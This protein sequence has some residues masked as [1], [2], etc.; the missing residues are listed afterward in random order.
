MSDFISNILKRHIESAKN[1]RPRIPGRFESDQNGLNFSSYE[2]PDEHN[3]IDQKLSE[4]DNVNH[5]PLEGSADNE[6]I[7]RQLHSQENGP[8]HSSFRGVK[9]NISMGRSITKPTVP[10]NG[11]LIESRDKVLGENTIIPGDEDFDGDRTQKN[12]D[13]RRTDLKKSGN[14]KNPEDLSLVPFVE[15]QV[16]KAK[17]KLQIFS[18]PQKPESRETESAS[19]MKK[20][21]Y[22]E[23]GSEGL[24]VMP[25]GMKEQKSNRHP[26]KGDT[27][28]ESPQVIKVHIGRIEVRAVTHQSSLPP[29]SKVSPKPR[30]SLDDYLKQINGG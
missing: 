3:L 30:L 16:E 24:L 18:N 17:Q 26:L 23:I 1:V 29:R 6:E 2:K 8:V 20:S 22:I 9:Q 19:G 21:K 25:P 4:V 13:F 15:Y 27:K 28:S 5:S 7:P 11:P 10:P 14:D 12:I